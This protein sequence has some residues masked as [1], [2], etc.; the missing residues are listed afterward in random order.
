[1]SGVRLIIGIVVMGV[2]LPLTLFFLLGLS[3]LSQFFTIAASTFLTWGLADLIASI[4]EKPRLSDRSPGKAFREDWNRR[5]K[6]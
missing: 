1:M 3:T 6:E 2:A 5:S 4:L